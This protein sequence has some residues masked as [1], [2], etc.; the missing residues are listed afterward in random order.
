MDFVKF[1]NKLAVE[2]I[3]LLFKAILS[4]Q[5]FRSMFLVV[6]PL[7]RRQTKSLDSWRGEGQPGL[8]ADLLR[9]RHH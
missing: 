2:Q 8:K 4:F 6:I 7:P 3:Y 5:A 1:L 9:A